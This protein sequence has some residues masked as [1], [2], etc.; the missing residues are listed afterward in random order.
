MIK[1]QWIFD[2]ILHP[3]LELHYIVLQR[4]GVYDIN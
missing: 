4:C 3:I 1:G 2:I